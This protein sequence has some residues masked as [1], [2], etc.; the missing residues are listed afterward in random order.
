MKLHSFLKSLPGVHYT[1]VIPV[2]QEQPTVILGIG[3]SGR[4]K[5]QTA[6]PTSRLLLVSQLLVL[7]ETLK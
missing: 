1:S 5:Q 4:T 6:K 2:I 3:D 7:L